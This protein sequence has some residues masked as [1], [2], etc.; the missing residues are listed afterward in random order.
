VSYADRFIVGNS[1]NQNALADYIICLSDDLGCPVPESTT[2]QLADLTV[3]STVF[4]LDQPYSITPAAGLT[5]LQLHTKRKLQDTQVWDSG[6]TLIKSQLDSAR[7]FLGNSLSDSRF[8]FL[9]QDKISWGL[10]Q[11]ILPGSKMYLPVFPGRTYL[12]LIPMVT[13]RYDLGP[14][15]ENMSLAQFDAEVNRHIEKDYNIIYF[16][17]TDNYVRHLA[18]TIKQR[19]KVHGLTTEQIYDGIYQAPW[20]VVKQMLSDQKVNVYKL[21]DGNYRHMFEQLSTDIDA[22]VQKA[23][24]QLN[25]FQDNDGVIIFDLGMIYTMN[26]A[27]GVSAYTNTCQQLGIKPN[28]Q[29]FLNVRDTVTSHRQDSTGSLPIDS[30]YREIFTGIV[31]V[32]LNRNTVYADTS[33]RD[34]GWNICCDIAVKAAFAELGLVVSNSHTPVTIQDIIDCAVKI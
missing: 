6:V 34:I 12:D 21:I 23:N 11:A 20:F 9:L 2:V 28:V 14:V 5:G 15:N 29:G 22:Y 13:S 31:Q 3:P 16:D 18:E 19:Q 10:A 24:Q 25:K 8:K 17:Q 32:V 27:D 7:D 26:T 30:Q 33:L 1:V 4:L